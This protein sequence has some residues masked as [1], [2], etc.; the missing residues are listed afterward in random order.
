MAGQIRY[1]TALILMGCATVPIEVWARSGR[2]A[3]EGHAL[4]VARCSGCHATEETGASPLRNAPPFRA[5]AYGYPV[6]TID[7]ALAEGIV[8]GHPDMPSDPWDP[9]DIRRFV[10]YLKSIGPKP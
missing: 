9:A 7:E 10:A 5:L 2:L 4:A 1:A 6:E 3:Q 8:A